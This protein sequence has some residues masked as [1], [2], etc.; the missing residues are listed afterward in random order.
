MDGQQLARHY[1]D[2]VLLNLKKAKRQADGALEQV[3]DEQFFALPGPESNSLAL[4]V[5]HVAGNQRSRFTDFLTSDGEKP[6]RDRDTEFERHA[7]DDRAALMARWD[8]GWQLVLD[9]IGSLEPGDL[10]RTV[11]VRGE[12]HSALQAIQRQVV[13]YAHHVGQIVF[14]AK[15]LTGGAW[16][17]LSI[18]RGRSKE[19]EVAQE[20]TRYRADARFDPAPKS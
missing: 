13:H 15:Q 18:P 14:L 5:K 1:L 6:D 3:D 2:D 4:I 7:G 16:R 10:L 8:A 9:T 11:T 12:E 20:G 19:F 17:T